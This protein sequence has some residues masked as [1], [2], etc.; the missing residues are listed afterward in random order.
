[1]PG[2]VK[3]ASRREETYRAKQGEC[4][5]DVVGG[6]H[7]DSWMKDGEERKAKFGTAVNERKRGRM[8]SAL[9][10]T[11]VENGEHTHVLLYR[12]VCLGR[13][14][15]KGYSVADDLAYAGSTDR[16]QLSWT[17]P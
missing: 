1:M 2:S 12:K 15:G 6:E 3:V 9:C 16:P 10:H 4:D 17:R 14:A 8:L 5:E 11:V 7:S 13:M